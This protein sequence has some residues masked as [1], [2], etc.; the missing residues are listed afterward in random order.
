LEILFVLICRTCLLFAFANSGGTVNSME[1][2]LPVDIGYNKLI[3]WLTSRKKLVP[4]WRKRLNVLHI[5]TATLSKTLPPGVLTGLPM[6]RGESMGYFN[7]KQVRHMLLARRR[8]LLVGKRQTGPL[9]VV[10]HANISLR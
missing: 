3:E 5:Q 4:D 1:G 10:T 7:C 9:F 6:G 8:F 2:D